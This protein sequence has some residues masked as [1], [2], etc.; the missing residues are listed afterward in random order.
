MTAIN[1]T[2]KY[3][4]FVDILGFKEIV[5][6]SSQADAS[7][8]VTDFSSMVY[9]SWRSLGYQNSN[10]INGFIVSDCVI[11]YTNSDKPSE[12]HSLLQLLL[13]IF[14]KAIYEN[15]IMLRASITKGAFEDLPTNTFEN[16]GKRLIVGQAYVEA[17]ILESKYKGS[18]IVFGQSV[19]D[20]IREIDGASY[21][22]SE[23]T[24][25][26]QNENET[27]QYYSLHWTNLEEFTR[28][29]NLRSFIKLANDSK[30]LSHYYTTIYLFIRDI[31]NEQHKREVL[32]Q[33]WI[34]ITDLDTANMSCRDTFIMN[35]FAEELSRPFRQMMAK[36][37]RECVQGNLRTDRLVGE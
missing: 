3:V 32:N 33:I 30:W 4:A 22:V 24:S 8:V 26:A 11:V 7:R 29:D 31:H 20:D 14:P 16:L 13:V 18:Q 34:C 25:T 21:L 2:C 28:E 19:R 10:K 37:F 35:A 5:K 12:L 6:R 27:D 1:T 23:I 36:Y 17:T 15:G 9:Q